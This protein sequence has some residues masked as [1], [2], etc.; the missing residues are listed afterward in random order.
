MNPNPIR[1]IVDYLRKYTRYDFKREVL[2]WL[3]IG[4]YYFPVLIPLLIFAVVGFIAIKPFPTEQTNLAI[5][6]QGSM[7]AQ[8]G[9]DFTKYFKK[10]GLTLNIQNTTGLEAGL[11]QLHDPNSKINASFVTSGTS[12]QSDHTELMS[13]GSVQIAPLWF[14]YRGSTVVTDD[15]FEY[16]KDKKIAVGAEG[17]I[18]NKLFNRMLELNTAST[19]DQ[20][21]HLKLPHAQAAQQLIDGEIEAMFIVDGYSSTVIQSLLKDP[22]IKL[23]TFPLADAYVRKLPFLQKVTVPRASLDIKQ[24]R[25]IQDIVLL[26]SSVNLLVDIDMH[27]AVQWAFLMAAQE[28]NLKSVDFFNASA[29][30]P[31]YQDK[32]FTLSEVA[33]RYYTSGIPSLFTYVPIWFGALIDNVWAPLLALYLL[34][35]PM[36]NKLIGYRS[37]ASQKLIWQHFWA[38]RYLEDEL[39]KCTTREKTD[40]VIARTIELRES[41]LSIWI[42]DV[43]LRHYFNLRR[44]IAVTLEDARKLAESQ[45]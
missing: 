6:Q 10:N 39:K 29:S 34:A 3:R 22:N 4:K 24:I 23:M 40:S 38:L 13:L 14:F 45:N 25:P 37:F 9:N 31:K 33:N 27:P 42:E 21:N 19:G 5:G 18:T 16:Y 20:I 36:L 28:S 11:N 15:P 43:D 17:T 26:A 12:K 1:S 41:L 30:Y 7:S 44:H 2:A 35:L 32:S 8:L